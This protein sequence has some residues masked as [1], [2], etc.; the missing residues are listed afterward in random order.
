LA[1]AEKEPGQRW[2]RVRH[3]F[4]ERG[5]PVSIAYRCWGPFGKRVAVLYKAK[6]GYDPMRRP[7]GGFIYPPSARPIF[8]QAWREF[9]VTYRF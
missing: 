1:T 3:Y 8:D 2:L 9:V 4:E 6:T 5:V 7:G